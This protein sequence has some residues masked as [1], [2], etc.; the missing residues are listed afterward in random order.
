[1]LLLDVRAGHNQSIQEWRHRTQS[2][3][4]KG[5]IRI[6][7]PPTTVALGRS[8]PTECGSARRGSD[9]G[10]KPI[11][12]NGRLLFRRQSLPASQSCQRQLQ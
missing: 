12:S 11:A 3:T 7:S 9:K 5:R 4:K 10:E 6:E 2:R 1:M 8:G